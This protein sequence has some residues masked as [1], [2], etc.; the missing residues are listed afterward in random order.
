MVFYQS[1]SNSTPQVWTMAEANFV[2]KFSST[3]EFH[4]C[5]DV[6]GEFKLGHFQFLE[7]ISSPNFL[8][9]VNFILAVQSVGHSNWAIWCTSFSQFCYQIFFN[10]WIS[11]MHLSLWGIQTGLFSVLWANFV[12]KF[13][14][15]CEFHSGILVFGAFKQ[16]HL[17]LHDPLLCSDY[18]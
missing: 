18:N 17:Q 15:I 13:C 14:S 16:G 12:F 6:F 5:I 8:Q 2:I 9:L 1:G 4:S 3:C 7:P 11:F 10:S